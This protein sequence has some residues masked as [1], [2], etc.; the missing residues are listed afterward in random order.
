V[1]SGNLAHVILDGDGQG[2]AR[3]SDD[4][5]LG[6][7]DRDSRHWADQSSRGIT[8]EPTCKTKAFQLAVEKVAVP[9]VECGGRGG[10]I[11]E[12]VAMLPLRGATASSG[13]DLHAPGLFG[14]QTVP[15]KT[16]APT[17]AFAAPRGRGR[18]KRQRRAKQKERPKGV[19]KS[20][21]ETSRR[22]SFRN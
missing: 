14:A 11:L 16:V 12:K 10:G 15:L 8:A 17:E 4:Q 9:R 19:E 18:H 5:F 13:A 2:T 7:Q 20:E 1:P 22:G 3:A 6:S 21:N